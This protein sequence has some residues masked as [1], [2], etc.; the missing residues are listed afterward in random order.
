MSDINLADQ[1][2]S[3][4]SYYLCHCILNEAPIIPQ[5]EVLI[6]SSYHVTCSEGTSKKK[7]QIKKRISEQS[8]KYISPIN[9]NKLL[10]VLKNVCC[11]DD[12][13]AKGFGESRKRVERTPPGI[14]SK[15]TNLTWEEELA[16][17][18]Q[19]EFTDKEE[20]EMI[21]EINEFLNTEYIEVDPVFENRE[22]QEADIAT[23]P[24]T[25]LKRLNRNLDEELTSVKKQKQDTASKLQQ[26]GNNDP[27]I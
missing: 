16:R 14:A 21:A 27:R 1:C 18:L 17:E 20:R 6:G 25:S 22:N 4:D 11:T 15:K 10:P 2:S 3:D 9:I 8:S 23:P 13:Y 5:S 26:L 7:G 24:E 12:D 19:H